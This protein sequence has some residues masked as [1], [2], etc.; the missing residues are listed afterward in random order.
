MVNYSKVLLLCFLFIAACNNP[1]AGPDKTVGGAV[2]GAAW[3]AG[4]GAI[5]GHQVEEFSR[6]GEGVAIGAGFG[7]VSGTA[8]GLGFDQMEDTQVE[9]EQQL[10][11]LHAQNITN[12]QEIED[13]QR[14]L[15]YRALN[16]ST[17]G[18]YQVF[19]DED[20]TS[21]RAGSLANLQIIADSYK[22]SP[23][24]SII[25]VI[26]HTDDTGDKKHNSQVAEA[27]ARSVSAYLISRGISADQIKVKEFGS[28][29]P[30]ASNS[31][32]AG[33][34]LNRRVDVYITRN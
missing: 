26:G 30:I 16:G 28:K 33:R 18:I 24:A 6:T 25:N 8:A 10:E 1:Q 17:G 13:I 12:R 32:S 19:F 22:S 2:L 23:V 29:R 21:I 14:R 27:R 31:T 20:A 5:V 34:Q 11:A 7:L 9:H 15:D 4:S 3:G